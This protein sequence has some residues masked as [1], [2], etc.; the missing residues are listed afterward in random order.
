MVIAAGGTGGG[1]YPALAVADALAAERPGVELLFV[2]SAGGMESDLVASAG[3]PFAGVS[4]GPLHGVGPVRMAS[5]AVKL[6]VGLAQAL[7]LLGR[8]RPAVVFTTGG[9]ASVPVSAAAWLRG[10]PVV[11]FVPDIE[12][13]LTLK[14][15][16]RLA[17]RVAATVADTAPYFAPGKVIATGYP[18]RPELCRATRAAAVE[19]FALD[20]ERQT[21]LVFGGSRGAESIN[22]AAAAVAGEWLADGVQVLHI[23]GK[24]DWPA[25][26]AVQTRLAD[27]HYHAFPYLHG[28]AMGLAFAAADLAVARGGAGILGEFPYFGLPAVVVPYPHAWRYQKVNADWLASRGAAVY[29]DDAALGD[30]LLPA[31]RGLLGAPARLAE[32]RAR[33]AAL[34]TRDGARNIACVV[35]EVA[36]A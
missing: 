25:V 19:H 20:P 1:I 26:Q 28:A 5:S 9:W 27:P 14:V 15:I 22:R 35:L 16:G 8:F 11:A 17:R 7:R 30:G 36:G 32:M 29:L 31:V 10:V 6:A 2:G 18:L 21:L 3:R 12:P 23:S 4:A 13:G 33:S 34:A 24:L